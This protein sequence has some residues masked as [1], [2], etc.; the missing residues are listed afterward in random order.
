MGT[1]SRSPSLYSDRKVRR[2]GRLCRM[3]AARSKPL[4][5]HALQ[6]RRAVRSASAPQADRAYTLDC[7][8]CHQ[9]AERTAAPKGAIDPSYHWGFWADNH[10]SSSPLCCSACRCFGPR[11]T[12]RAAGID[13]FGRHI[14]TLLALA[15]ALTLARVSLITRR[16]TCDV[17]LSPCFWAY[18]SSPCAHRAQPSARRGALWVAVL[19]LF[20]AAFLRR[21][22]PLYPAIAILVAGVG[23]E[24]VLMAWPFLGVTIVA[25][26]WH[27]DCT[28]LVAPNELTSR[29][30]KLQRP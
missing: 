21:W 16:A 30:L 3:C 19:V 28:R 18:G 20:I 1:W 11:L 26:Y 2:D 4:I 13:T 24:L 6:P 27:G 23:R 25:A 14:V 29:N 22:L 17:G 5:A 10:P 15:L 7:C 12:L 8:H 9:A